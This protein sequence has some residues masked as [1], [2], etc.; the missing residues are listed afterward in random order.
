[1]EVM[2]LQGIVENGHFRLPA[3][4]RLPENAMVYAV[5]PGTV[6]PRVV[7]V[8]PRLVHPERVA[9]FKMVAQETRDASL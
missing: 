3:N 2:T 9:D 4:V 5:I 8:S 1:M 6:A 7:C